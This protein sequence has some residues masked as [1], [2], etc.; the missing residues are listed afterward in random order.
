MSRSAI[1]D[2]LDSPRFNGTSEVENSE[3]RLLEA[4]IALNQNTSA[5]LK[6]A[7]FAQAFDPFRSHD[8]ANDARPRHE[9]GKG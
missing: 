2:V 7:A 8:K 9:P 6:L 4:V 1:L 5:A 3:Q